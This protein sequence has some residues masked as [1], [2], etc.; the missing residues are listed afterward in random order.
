MSLHETMAGQNGGFS[1]E[2]PCTECGREFP[3]TMLIPL[4]RS[5]ALVCLGC[6]LKTEARRIRP[7]KRQQG[8]SEGEAG[9]D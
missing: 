1:K 3:L 8:K 4:G 5:E 7:R 2:R 6:W 9:A